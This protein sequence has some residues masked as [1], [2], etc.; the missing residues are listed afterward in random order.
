MYNY[1]YIYKVIL[2]FSAVWLK[3]PLTPEVVHGQ[4]DLET[5]LSGGS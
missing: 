4:L 2:R 3:V 1:I 5:G